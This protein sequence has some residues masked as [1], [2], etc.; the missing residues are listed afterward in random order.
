MGNEKIRRGSEIRLGQAPCPT[1]QLLQGPG[2][3][4]V[5]EVDATHVCIAGPS[6]WA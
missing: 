3:A 5:A 4:S 2:V 6:C 1:V